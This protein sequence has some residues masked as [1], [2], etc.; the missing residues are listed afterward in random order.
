MKRDDQ[1][2]INLALFGNG[3]KLEL[4]KDK[5]RALISTYLANITSTPNRTFVWGFT[6]AFVALH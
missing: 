3:P 2:V 4:I 6:P 5:S 1:Q